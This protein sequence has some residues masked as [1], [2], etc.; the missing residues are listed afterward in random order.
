VT[1][2]IDSLTEECESA[3]LSLAKDTEA[4]GEKVDTVQYQIEN[5]IRQR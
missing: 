5:D 3:V 1:D 4:M 2:R